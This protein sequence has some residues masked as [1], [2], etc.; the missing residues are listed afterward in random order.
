[1]T[2][3]RGIRKFVLKCGVPERLYSGLSDLKFFWSYCS[4]QYEE[5]LQQGLGILYSLTYNASWVLKLP[6][7]TV[8]STQSV[9]VA[10]WG[11]PE[12]HS[13]SYDDENR[14]TTIRPTALG[15]FHNVRTQRGRGRGGQS[16]C[17]RTAYRGV[18][19]C[20]C[21][22]RVRKLYSYRTYLWWTCVRYAYRGTGS[23]NSW[24]HAYVLYR[25][26]RP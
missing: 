16:G 5:W 10:I 26:A 6:G 24:F 4:R 20:V 21:T 3:K 25:R 19:P 9:L 2:H 11:V 14:R 17:V 8:I 12:S 13:R 15:F 1:M 22:Q 23:E 7:S 18:E